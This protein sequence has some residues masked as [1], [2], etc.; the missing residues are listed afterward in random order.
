MKLLTKTTDYDETINLA[1]KLTGEYDKSVVFHCYWHGNLNEK[2]LYSVLSCYYF[3]VLN[4][5][6]KIILWLEN[7]TPNDINEEISKY[8]EIKQFSLQT[9]KENTNFIEKEFYYNKALSFYSDVV[10]YLLLYNYLK[11]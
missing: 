1:N 11:S 10:R 8:C 5:N 3:N 9:E 7:N 6:H 2:H 4:R